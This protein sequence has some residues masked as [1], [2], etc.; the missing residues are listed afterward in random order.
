MILCQFDLTS[1]TKQHK[2]QVNISNHSPSTFKTVIRIL[3]LRFLEI[4]NKEMI[5]LWVLPKKLGL[6]F[7]SIFFLL[8][9]AQEYDAKIMPCRWPHHYW[10]LSLGPGVNPVEPSFEDSTNRSVPFWV[11]PILAPSCIMGLLQTCHAKKLQ[12]QVISYKVFCSFCLSS[13]YYV[14]LITCILNA[15]W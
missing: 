12:E 2:A 7:T 13:R 11:G 10:F 15:N 9:L 6:H 5:E 8:E 4:L 1:S 3:Q 14:I